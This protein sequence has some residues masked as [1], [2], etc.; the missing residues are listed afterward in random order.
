M[1]DEQCVWRRDRCQPN[2]SIHFDLLS[3]CKKEI[4][5]RAFCE[6]LKNESTPCAMD[7]VGHYEGCNPYGEVNDARADELRMNFA[8]AGCSQ[9]LSAVLKRGVLVV[10]QCP[11]FVPLTVV[12]FLSLLQRV[13][14]RGVLMTGD[15]MVRQLFTRMIAFV[16]GATV[17]GEHYFHS[18]AI[19]V[20]YRNGSDEFVLLNS[21]SALGY[22]RWVLRR[23]FP[24]HRYKYT[25]YKY[26]GPSMP[27]EGVIVAVLYQWDPRPTTFRR[28]F[29]AMAHTMQVSS[30]MYHWREGDSISAI[31]AYLKAVTTRQRSRN[32]SYFFISTPPSIAINDST[33]KV[34]QWYIRKKLKGVPQIRWID[35]ESI[36]RSEDHPR[37]DSFHYQCQWGGMYPS[38]VDNLRHDGA[39]CRDVMNLGVMQ[40]WGYLMAVKH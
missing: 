22:V 9:Q 16:R 6:L 14:P 35:F 31:D 10:P 18:D 12:D 40:R 19:F 34:R 20:V 38:P 11:M 24:H 23:F 7:M 15:S 5:S 8:I 3:R 28:M 36:A 32:T 27:D 13:S 33:L 1:K 25:S 26:F 2:S 29:K 37:I 30:F 4:I 17:V 21:P 39:G